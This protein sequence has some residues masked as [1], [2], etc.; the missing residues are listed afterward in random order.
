MILVSL[1]NDKLSLWKTDLNQP[2]KINFFVPYARRNQK[3][4]KDLIDR[5]V[6]NLTPVEQFFC[7]ATKLPQ[8]A[9]FKL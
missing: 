9:A 6:D 5:L 7:F 4:A 2:D 1:I 3:L 8:S